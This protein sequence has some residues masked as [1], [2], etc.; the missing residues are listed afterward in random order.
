[1]VARHL[2]DPRGG[3]PARRHPERVVLALDDERRDADGVELGQ[4]ALL[5]PARGGGSGER[6]A[7][8]ADRA[9]RR[10]GAAGDA[11]AGGAA[12]GDER[13]AAEL[14]RAE[15]LDDRRPRGVEL[16]GRRGRRRPATR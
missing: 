3:A 5:R 10:S 2:D 14:A 8:H 12:A 15:L 9:G 1:M 6:E 16:A 7:E 13:Q 11:R 4:A